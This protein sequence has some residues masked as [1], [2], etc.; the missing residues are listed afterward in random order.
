[1]RLR[2]L[3]PYTPAETHRRSHDFKLL[4][5][6][7]QRLV[8]DDLKMKIAI[9]TL[10]ILLLSSNCHAQQE[11]NRYQPYTPTVVGGLPPGSKGLEQPV[12][13]ADRVAPNQLTDTT[14]GAPSDFLSASSLGF[15]VTKVVPSTDKMDRFEAGMLIAVVGEDPVL[16]GDLFPINKLTPNVTSDSQ[17]EMA[18]RKGLMEIVTRKALAQR[19]LNDKV[20]GKAVKDRA[21][22]KKQMKTQTAKIFHQKW[23]PMQ[24]E[25]MKCESSLEFQEK[26]AEAGKTLQSMMRDFAERTWAQEHVREKVP[27]NPIIEL[28]ELSDY[29][30]EH[31]DDF[32]RPARARFQMLSA[33]FSKFPSKQDAFQAIADMGNQVLLGGAPFSAVAKRQSTGLGASEGGL[34]D[35]TTQGALKSKEIDKAIFENSVRGLSQ[36]IETSDGYH[37]VEVLEREQ[38]YTQ[39]FAQAQAEI[40][41]VLVQ[42]KVTKQRNDFIAKVRVETPIWT[43]WP[44]DIPGS[45]N[46]S[47]LQQ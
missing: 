37:I 31:I 14:A 32:K 17:F 13:V 22:A 36:V 34:F 4:N 35:W 11:P 7:Q 21:E 28:S 2:P 29:F 10:A 3:F 43:K 45:Q 15:D 6:K 33:N 18:M 38:A 1:M 8:M 23:I 41:K 20:S 47:L 46:I 25:Q 40:R 16:I 5:I 26:L 9:S 19:F 42:Q 27:E 24:M 44:E 30:Q 39:T 12:Y